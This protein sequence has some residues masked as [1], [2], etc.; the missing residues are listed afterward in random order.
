MPIMSRDIRGRISGAAL[1]CAFLTFH[2]FYL[3]RGWNSFDTAAKANSLLITATI[4]LYLSSYFLR[5]NPVRFPEGLRE[6]VFPLFCAVLPLVI[7]HNVELLR[8]VPVQSKYYSIFHALFGLSQN[9]LLRWNFLSMT[10][11]LFGNFITLAGM[12]SLRRSF[13]LMVEAREPVFTGL[14]SYV[15][16]PL[17]IGETIATAGVLVFRFSPANVFLFLLFVA[18]QT[19]RAALEEKKLLA[20]FPEYREYRRQT[21]AFFPRSL[22]PGFQRIGARRK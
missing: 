17:Y 14:Y 18:C 10:L 11:A 19:F 1:F 20:V 4:F 15:R 5:K 21:G 3:T 16:H 7:Y 22:R 9:G 8:Y 12:V 6:T 2:L 13:S